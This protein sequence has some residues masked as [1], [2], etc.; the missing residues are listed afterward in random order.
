[1][2]LNER[3]H[4]VKCFISMFFYSNIIHVAMRQILTREVNHVI[5]YLLLVQYL[6]K[7]SGFSN[8]ETIFSTLI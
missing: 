8:E 2:F 6:L 7:P 3:H 5:I 4:S 1:M